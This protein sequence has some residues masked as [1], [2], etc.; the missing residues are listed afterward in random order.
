[1]MRFFKQGGVSLVELLIAGLILIIVA[2]FVSS[3]FMRGSINVI[4]SWEETIVLSCMQELVEEVKCASR[5]PKGTY[6]YIIMREDEDDNINPDHYHINIPTLVHD[7]NTPINFTVVAHS[8]VNDIHA[9]DDELGGIGAVV[10]PV[11]ELKEGNIGTPTFTP[12]DIDIDNGIGHGEIKFPK[13]PAGTTRA[14]GCL[15]ILG[16]PCIRN[17]IIYPKA[18]ERIV[19]GELVGSRT[20]KF[21]LFDDPEDNN[22]N[23]LLPGDYMKGTITFTWQRTKGAGKMEKNIVTIIAPF[24]E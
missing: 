8:V 22:P 11:W 23:D 24:P 16:S 14:R 10:T 4:T 6:T 5:D 18:G 12:E 2:L 3:I 13:L 17:I 20:A 21:E 15:Y 9:R 7:D 19:E 1:M